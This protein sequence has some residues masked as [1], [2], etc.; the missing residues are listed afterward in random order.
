ML[1]FQKLKED[2]KT[3]EYKNIEIADLRAFIE[4]KIEQMIARNSTRADFAQ[5]LQEIIDRYNAGGSSTENYFD[6]LVKFTESLKDEEE[7]AA[8]EGLSEDEL[9][10]FDILKKEKMTKDET[11]KVKLAAKSLL[12]RLTRGK[13]K[14]LVQDWYKDSQTQ[15]KVKTAVEKVLDKA[16]PESYDKELFQ[17]KRDN[18]YDLIYGYSLRKMKWAA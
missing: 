7:R 17:I 4:G 15:E 12:E 11:Q 10:I 13:P 6:E 5:K 18:V 14:V 3:K 9:E 2:F 16:L 8:R 1:D